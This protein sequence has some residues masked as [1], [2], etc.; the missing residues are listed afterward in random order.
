[1]GLR[2]EQS[3]SEPVRAIF[4]VF[5]VLF[6]FTA[7]YGAAISFDP[8]AAV[9]RLAY[10]AIGIILYFAIRS[11]PEPWLTLLPV[12]GSALAGYFLLS[13]D[14]L[15]RLGKLPALDPLLR[16]LALGPSLF[17]MLPVNTNTIGGV[18]SMLMPIQAVAASRARGAPRAAAGAAFVLS[19]IALL[20]TLSRG[21]VLALFGASLCAAVYALLQRAPGSLRAQLRR[22]SPF[23]AALGVTLTFCGGIVMT[24]IG[25]RSELA[26][27][28]LLLRDY[29]LTGIG[30]DGFA[31]AYST[32][33]L[34]T[35]VP[36]LQH[37]HNLY[38]NIWLSQGL[39]GLTAFAGM[40]FGALFAALRTRA[41]S[42]GHWPLGGF[43]GLVVVLA[44]GMIDDPFHGD[45]VFLPALFVPFALL[46]RSVPE[47]VSVAARVRALARASAQVFGGLAALVAVAWLFSAVRSGVYANLGALRQAQMEL[48]VYR[49]GMNE[50]WG[51]PDAARLSLRGP[52]NESMSYYALAL[53]LNPANSSANRRLGQIELTFG[54]YDAAFKHLAAAYQGDVSNYTTRLLAGE[55]FA[56][57]GDDAQRLQEAA[58][59]WRGVP[60]VRNRLS[61]RLA[62]YASFIKDNIRASRMEAALALTIR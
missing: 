2:S 29:W 1:M 34:L 62:W 48:G 27:V 38:A 57:S 8:T 46:L 24:A 60:E 45:V 26:D 16:L 31:L 43:L 30:F 7:L 47:S 19:A 9:A 53:G 50:R 42:A 5:F 44:H 35:H 6:A 52:M 14:W 20:L 22:A 15:L 54:L 59:I 10:F 28:D 61:G 56:V 3:D 25:T 11:M 23:L 36:F 49:N 18:L 58:E 55:A 21:A 12:A 13:N 51:L 4:A 17:P 33:A 37:A 32:Y 39:L 40:T 41:D